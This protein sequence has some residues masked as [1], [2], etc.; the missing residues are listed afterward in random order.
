MAR[1]WGKTFN[2][3]TVKEGDELPVLIKWMMFIN[4]NNEHSFYAPEHL[5]TYVHE[6]II[7]TIPIQNPSDNLDWI[8]IELSQEIPMNANLSLLGIITSKNSNTGKGLTIT[9]G[10]ESDDGAVQET[11]VAEVTVEEQI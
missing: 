5:K 1:L 9:F 8:T 4:Q 6:A 3:E 7:K 2:Y 11:A 10:I